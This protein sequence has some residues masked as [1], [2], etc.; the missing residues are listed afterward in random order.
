MTNLHWCPDEITATLTTKQALKNLLY[1]PGIVIETSIGWWLLSVYPC[2]LGAWVGYFLLLMSGL[3]LIAGLVWYLLW[4]ARR[5][6]G[7][8][9]LTAA[10]SL[11][12]VGLLAISQW[13]NSN[14]AVIWGGIFIHVLP[15][16]CAWRLGKFLVVRLFRVLLVAV[17][18]LGAAWRGE[19]ER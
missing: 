2:G 5:G 19:L 13:F 6:L 7:P 15:V 1:V 17:A 4:F 18:Q 9:F 10:L 8:W 12:G 11:I 3:A 16:Y 14:A